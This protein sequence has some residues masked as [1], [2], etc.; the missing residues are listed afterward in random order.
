MKKI[1][2]ANDLLVGGGVENLLENLVRYL[3]QHEYDVSLMIPNCTQEEVDALFGEKVTLYPLMRNLKKLKKF[4]LKWF[5]DRGCYLFQKFCYSVQFFLKQYDVTIAL[6]EGP[7]MIELSRLYS[8]KRLAWI[9]SDH[10]YMNWTNYFFSSIEEELKCM[11]RYHN[12]VCVSEA[13]KT[14][15][16]KMIGDP[17]N[18]CVKYN[19]IDYKKIREKAMMPCP[20]KKSAVGPLFVSIGRLAYPKNYSMLLDVCKE[21][22]REYS[23]EV[24]IIGDGPD[25]NDL[26]EKI[27]MWGLDCVKLLGSKEN[28]FPYL[29]QAD[30]FI[31]TS[32]VESYG[33]AVQEALVLGKPVVAVKCPAIEE[34]FE[35]RF[36][37]L[38]MP[39]HNSLKEAMEVFL[40]DLKKVGEFQNGVVE[41]YCTEELFE[42]RLAA[43]ESLWENKNGQQ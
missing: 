7:T 14:S 40:L 37:L 5:C 30:I 2:I 27:E 17:G 19:P 21:L 36:G 18:I 25:K 29:N 12:V 23:F 3:L 13:A 24:W 41:G 42:T 20:L 32:L 35:E 26:Q 11:K 15:L 38:T 1:L 9:H 39:D 8:K 43:I 10:Q 28:P 22:I 31:S 33:L 4:S 16:I 6:K 34:N